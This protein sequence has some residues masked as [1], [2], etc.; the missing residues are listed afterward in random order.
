MGTQSFSMRRSPNE[1]S[2][3]ICKPWPTKLARSIASLNV[4]RRKKSFDN[5]CGS[6]RGDQRRFPMR[7]RKSSPNFNTTMILCNETNPPA[8]FVLRPPRVSP[9]ARSRR[10]PRSTT[11]RRSSMLRATVSEGGAAVAASNITT[12]LPSALVHREDIVRRLQNKRVAVFLDYD[13]SLTP[14]VERPDQALLSESMRRTIRQLATHC[15]VA[16]ISGRDRTD[17]Q[18]LVR[19]DT[20]IYAGSHGF[21]IAGPRSM[22]LRYES[23]AEFLPAIEQAEGTLRQKLA[24]VRGAVVEHKKF[25]IAVHV[26]AVAQ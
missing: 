7:A 25:T 11:D 23:G 26:R 14:I 21:D 22:P 16:I 18:H 10:L 5:G 9:C 20:I 13:G 6:A 24:G 17:V 4:R 2:A 12:D 3:N 19:I 15:P 1:P 8:I